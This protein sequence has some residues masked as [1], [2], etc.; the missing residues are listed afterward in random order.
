MGCLM[1]IRRTI[2]YEVLDFPEK[3]REALNKSP[4]AVTDVAREIGL[5]GTQ[6][7][8]DLMSGKRDSVTYERVR[9]LE[10]AL[11]ADFGVKVETEEKQ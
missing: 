1:R 10:K 9:A 2:E 4:K 5:K 8:Y 11:D 3:L 7:I 6:Y